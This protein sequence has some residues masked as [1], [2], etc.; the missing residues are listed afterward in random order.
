MLHRAAEF[1]LTGLQRATIDMAAEFLCHIHC[2]SFA[3]LRCHSLKLR[4]Q[5]IQVSSPAEAKFLRRKMAAFVL[6]KQLGQPHSIGDEGPQARLIQHIGGE[7][8]V[9]AVHEQLQENRTVAG[10]V[11]LVNFEIIERNRRLVAHCVDNPG[12]ASPCLKADIQN[13][14]Y[15]ICLHRYKFIYLPQTY[16]LNQ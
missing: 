3:Q 12:V 13:L 8:A 16:Q 2:K 14:L 6:L 4:I 15:L 7:S 9:A 5:K 11:N 1:R 10:V